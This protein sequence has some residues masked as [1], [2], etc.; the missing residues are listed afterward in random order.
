MSTPLFSVVI[1]AYNKGNFIKSSVESVLNQTIG[2]FEMFVIDDGSRDNTRKKVLSINDKRV[3][4]F[5]QDPSGLP[6]SARNRGI[7]RTSGKYIAL[8]D[9]DDAWLPDKLKK[10]QGVFEDHPDADI[11]S[12]D[13]KI[14]DENDNI[15]RRTYHGP[16]PENMYDKLLWKGN[17][18]GV[19]QTVL[20]R[21][22]FFEHNFWFD[23]DKKLFSVEDYDFWLRLAETKKFNFYY[24]SDILARHVISEGGIVLCDIERNTMNTLYLFDKNIKKKN[25]LGDK[26]G[27]VKKRRSAMM[28]SAALSYNYKN[29]YFKSINWFMK[30]AKEYPSSISNYIGVLLSLL[31]IRLGRV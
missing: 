19:S 13:L 15:I 5:Y 4:Y 7:E 6:A 9:G 8:L 22:V 16:Y 27:L 17:C 12:H 11:I 29:E 25:I 14:T 1:T 28:R 24:L 21:E 31:R 3:K 10:V 23:E 18:L 26:Q 20:K 2:D 30:A